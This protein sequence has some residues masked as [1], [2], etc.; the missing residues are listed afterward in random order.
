[1]HKHRNAFC[2]GLLCLLLAA[3]ALGQTPAGTEPKPAPSKQ[4]VDHAPAA[5][6]ATEW[7]H[8][9]PGRQRAESIE[10]DRAR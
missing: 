1:M 10:A 3:P 4:P 7:P 9:D 5:P 6:H 2:C 8:N